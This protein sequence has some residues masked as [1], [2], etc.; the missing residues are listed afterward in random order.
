METIGNCIESR[1]AANA[2]EML[3]RLQAG[4]TDKAIEKAEQFLGVELPEQVKDSYRLHNGEASEGYGLIDG[5]E[6]LSLERITDEWKV[7]QSDRG[8]VQLDE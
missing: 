7:S 6:F 5:W 2:P 1:L 8:L 3:H 4:T